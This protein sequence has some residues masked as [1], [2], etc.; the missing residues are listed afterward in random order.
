V[1]VTRDD[2]FEPIYYNVF[3]RN[4]IFLKET[5]DEKVLLRTI[6]KRI[7]PVAT[8]TDGIERDETEA[9]TSRKPK[10]RD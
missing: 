1:N 5:G 9:P 10:L 2:N 7:E 8:S 6:T 3:L 4:R